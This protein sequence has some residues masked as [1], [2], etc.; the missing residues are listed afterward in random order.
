MRVVEMGEETLRMAREAHEQRTRHELAT[1][2]RGKAS[3]ARQKEKHSEAADKTSAGPYKET[4][5][6][7]YRRGVIH[8]Y[9]GL[10]KPRRA[11][12]DRGG[13]TLP[14]L[15]HEWKPNTPQSWTA[16]ASELIFTGPG[17]L[18]A[19]VRDSGCRV[20]PNNHILFGFSNMAFGDGALTPEFVPG[21]SSQTTRC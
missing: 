20:S 3:E 2:T 12:P 5:A 7:A 8:Q 18:A 11:D 6:I 14:L 16:H 9:G 1:E 15:M 10:D 19:F 21:R 17:A 4:K 13:A